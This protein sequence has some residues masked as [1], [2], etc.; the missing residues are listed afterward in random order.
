MTYAARQARHEPAAASATTAGRTHGT[1]GFDDRSPQGARLAELAQLMNHGP[2]AVAQRRAWQATFDGRAQPSAPE[3]QPV[4]RAAQDAPTPNRTGMPDGLKSGI[5]SLSGVSMDDVK[6]HYNSSQPAQ[7]HARAFAQGREIHLAPGQEHHL[8]H[9]AWHV[10]QQA[11]G[12]VRPT[13]QLKDSMP[14]NDDAGL[15]HEADVMGA[16]AMAGPLPADGTPVRDMQLQSQ[17][18]VTPPAIAQRVTDDEGANVTVDWAALT[19]LEARAYRKKIA[20]EGW[21][22]TPNE[23]VVLA[24]KAGGGGPPAPPELAA[25]IG[26]VGVPVVPLPGMP[27]NQPNSFANFTPVVAGH[28]T[29]GKLGWEPAPGALPDQI[30]LMEE[31]FREMRHRR[32]ITKRMFEANRLEA[33]GNE[34]PG[35]P[36]LFGTIEGTAHIPANLT[37]PDGKRVGPPVPLAANVAGPLP[38]NI[39]PAQGGLGYA[40]LLD[41]LQDE[42]RL[43]LTTRPFAAGAITADPPVNGLAPIRLGGNQIGLLTIGAA[44]TYHVPIGAPGAAVTRPLFGKR[45][46]PGKEYVKD[47]RGTITA[48]KAY[49]EKNF[50]QFMDFLTSGSMSGRYQSFAKAIGEAAPSLFRGTAKPIDAGGVAP[51][52]LLT[53]EQMAVLHQWMGSGPEQ[54]GL[55]LT[56]SRHGLVLANAGKSFRTGQGFRIEIDLALVPD[57]VIVINHYARDGVRSALAGI[58]NRIYGPANPGGGGQKYNYT[59]SVAKNRELFLERLE[60]AWITNVTWHGAAA[61]GANAN[62]GGPAQ[63]GA[64]PAWLA[65]TQAAVGQADFVNGFDAMRVALPHPAL[66]VFAG[67]DRAAWIRQE[68]VARGLIVHR[69]PNPARPG[70]HAT[71]LEADRFAQGASAAKHY[72]LG[73]F[74]GSVDRVHL[75]GAATNYENV[76]GAGQAIGDYEAAGGGMEHVPEIYSIGYAH[77]LRGLAP[78]AMNAAFLGQVPGYAPTAIPNGAAGVAPV[79][80]VAPFR[81]AVSNVA[82]HQPAQHAVDQ[83]V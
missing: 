7:L 66:P 52:G 76:K 38:L 82:A 6:V 50:W 21:T 37:A 31:A 11:Q 32:T 45:G 19:E 81:A 8:P 30:A 44:N 72:M 46:R 74:H 39:I 3:N 73:H 2:R 59:G 20:D 55:S 61:Y 43:L 34:H 22:A 10:V 49:C 33:V 79:G 1:A 5:E 80:G 65:N 47:N 18:L 67:G 4:Q 24:W 23:T 69:T 14:I 48:R 15:E 25:L 70:G 42:H 28:A 75:A 41:A 78:A 40:Q 83:L 64:P 26:P 58:N 17:P 63:A 62:L 57:D 51:A 53:M 27:P 29:S 9:E 68:V 36:E 71:P 56:S 54:R 12:R 77:G 60:P 16:R 13:R 35:R